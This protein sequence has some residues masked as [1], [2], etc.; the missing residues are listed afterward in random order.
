MGVGHA[1]ISHHVS[2]LRVGLISFQ[3]MK[4][5]HVRFVYVNRMHLHSYLIFAFNIYIFE[6]FEL[7]LY[8]NLYR[9]Y[10]LWILSNL[11]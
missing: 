11:S 7:Y 6:L 3:C 10:G 4:N 5:T 8:N 1:S 2:W 9:W